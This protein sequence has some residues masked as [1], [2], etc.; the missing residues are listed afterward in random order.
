[1]LVEHINR[2]GLVLT[3]TGRNPSLKPIL[4]TAHQDVVPV[5][6]SSTWKHPPFSGHFDGE[7]LWGR[8]ASDDKNSLVGILSAMET[9]LSLGWQPRRT[10]ILAFGFDEESSGKYGAGH[11]ATHLT[12]RYG[13]NSMVIL[14]D[15]GGFGNQLIGDVLYA[16][17]AVTEK[18]HIDIWYELHVQGG[19]SSLPFPHTGIGIVAEIVAKLEANPYQASLAEGSP[20]HNHFV[21]QARYS[22]KADKRIT[23]LIKR[24][25]LETLASELAKKDRSLR[26]RIQTSQSVD[27]IKGVSG[28]SVYSF[29]RLLSFSRG[30]LFRALRS[31][32]CQSSL[33]SVLTT[34]WPCTTRLKRSS[35]AVFIS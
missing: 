28:T 17:P 22:P 29:Q 23:K 20:V 1:M 11:I 25:D 30:Q 8:G 13:N 26:F 33:D 9:L 32:R 18:G 14:V 24:G 27:I 12:A 4:L 31:M 15:E 19:H 16:F 2:F 3:A 5:A 7:W 6:D 35:S 10:V 34:A 21:C